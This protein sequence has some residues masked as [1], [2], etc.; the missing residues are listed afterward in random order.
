MVRG[1]GARNPFNDGNS[2]DSAHLVII[3]SVTTNLLVRCWE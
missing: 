1:R 2:P 3:V